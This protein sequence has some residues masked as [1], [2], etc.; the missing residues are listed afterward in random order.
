VTALL[1]DLDG[2]LVDSIPLIVESFTHVILR[3]RGVPPKPQEI[4][5]GIGKKLVV[6]MAAFAEDD[7]ERDEMVATYSDYYRT[8]SPDALRP[9]DGCVDALRALKH[10]GVPMGIVTSKSMKGT[11]RSIDIC[12]LDG[13]FD[14][15][16]SADCVERG[17]PDPEPVHLALSKLGVDASD[18]IFVGDST[19]D[20][21]AGQAAGVRT[22]AVR[23][24]AF[25][26]A[27]LERLNPD[28]W[29]ESPSHL[30]GLA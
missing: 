27:A 24:T 21:E 8:R 23:W 9:F 3:H 15:L 22:A 25:E 12:G 14:V 6:Q 20:I 5:S 4:I 10:R 11:V 7:E 30:T 16:V 17:K 28:H 19:H 18:A 26:M 1:L 13:L 29:L 2:T